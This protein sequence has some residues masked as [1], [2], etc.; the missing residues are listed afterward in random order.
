MIAR[1]FMIGFRNIL[2]NKRRTFITSLVI[3]TGMFSLILTDGFIHG[4]TNYMIQSGT[5]D[6]Y[7][8]G[9]IRHP[10][11]TEDPQL[12]LAIKS[13]SIIERQLVSRDEVSLFTK[14]TYAAAMISSAEDQR[15]IQLIGIEP[16]TEKKFSKI[17]QRIIKGHFLSGE[18]GEIIMGK[19][20][21]KRLNI[22][23]GERIVVTTTSSH[24]NQ[25]TQALFYLTGVFSFENKSMDSDL[26]F[27]NLKQ[28]Q[29]LLELDKRVHEI[30]IQF[31]D[32]N[33]NTLS[34]WKDL[35]NGEGLIYESWQ[36]FLK[37]L[38]ATINMTRKSILI[39]AFI[40]ALLVFFTVTNTLHM[41]LLERI[42][43]FGVLRA[44]GTSKSRLLGTIIIESFGL[45]LLGTLITLFLIAT[46]G[47]YLAFYGV[48]YG[49][50]SYNQISLREPI[51]FIFRPFQ[52]VF[53]ISI[54]IL[55][56][57]FISLYPAWQI[58]RVK[59]ADALQS[60]A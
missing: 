42:F 22:D 3:A 29:A 59:P 37:P 16:A 31:E 27:I 21:A 6:F 43:E 55:F 14:R 34:S 46:I 15:N 17:A 56:V 44:I 47:G 33:T 39:V 40:L 7:G 36:D 20:L 48:D 57:C 11:F 41:A 18:Y 51:Y 2:R 1:M 54:S 38:A 53:Y 32:I 19:Q 24:E 35:A 58:L 52:I 25:L 8:Q 12:N 13:P 60:R 45:A 49:G 26:V 28:S 23:L 50:L 30:A 4:F 10:L 9:R 5:S